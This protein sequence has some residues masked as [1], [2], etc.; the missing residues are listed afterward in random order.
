MGPIHWIHGWGL[1]YGIYGKFDGKTFLD[2]LLIF[3][4]GGRGGKRKRQGTVSMVGHWTTRVIKQPHF[5]LCYILS[6]GSLHHVFR[7]S[8]TMT[9][10]LDSLDRQV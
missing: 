7:P 5:V 9:P 4:L 6:S 10:I 1:P 3:F 8:R 2:G